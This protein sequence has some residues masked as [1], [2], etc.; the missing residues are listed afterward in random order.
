[1]LYSFS[2]FFESRAGTDHGSRLRSLF[3]QGDHRGSSSSEISFIASGFYY[4]F[5][6]LRRL[7]NQAAGAVGSPAAAAA[8]ACSCFPHV[9][10]NSTAPSNVPIAGHA[11]LAGDQKTQPRTPPLGKNLQHRP[12]S[13]GSRLLNP[14]PV[15]PP[16]L[17][18]TKGMK[19]SP[20]HWTSTPT[21]SSLGP[22]LVCLRDAVSIPALRPERFRRVRTTDCS[23]AASARR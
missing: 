17:I 13:S 10:P 11:L 3:G 2:I 7:A 6:P 12:P 23:G 4:F 5:S 18:P 15:P 20:I 14:A 9:L 8:C 19:V 1:M 22:V 21:C 16:N